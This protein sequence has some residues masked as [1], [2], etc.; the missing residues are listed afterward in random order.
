MRKSRLLGVAIAAGTMLA[1]AT[2][3][4]VGAVAVHVATSASAADS[5]A[6]RSA[7]TVLRKSGR[8][9]GRSVR[10]TVLDRGQTATLRT[11]LRAGTA[12]RTHGTVDLCARAGLA[13][14]LS[15]LTAAKT[16]T[17]P[18]ASSYGQL[19]YG[20]QDLQ[21]AYGLAGAKNASSTVAVVETGT[22]PKLASDLAVYRRAN[23]LPA[24]TVAGR[25]L[26]VVNQNGGTKLEPLPTGLD[27]RYGEEDVAGETA[28]D[29]DMV[30]AACPTCHI[31]VVDLP[32]KDAYFPATTARADEQFRDFGAGV[33]SAVRL[34]ARGVSLS[35]G[36]PASHYGDTVAAAP[37]NRP[38]VVI[39]ASSGD[40]GA[41][42]DAASWP[43]NLTTVISAGGTSLHVSGSGFRQSAWAGAG[44]SCSRDLRPAAGQPASV[45][46][47]CGGH[48]ASSDLSTVADPNTGVS[49]Y[50]SFA[51][52]SGTPL[53][54][55][56]FGGTSA[57]APF[58]A[59]M[60]VRA[61]VRADTLGPNHIYRAPTGSIVD[62]TAGTNAAGRCPEHD[63]RACTAGRGW[64]GPT[65]LG[66]PKGLTAFG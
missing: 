34:G 59:A 61:G 6:A 38:G 40:S 27:P 63:P 65:G 22:Y 64:D 30:S 19:G 51:P 8:S 54:F 5:G 48:R 49:V 9:S 11:Q 16:S 15:A 62:V 66:T 33:T 28:L 17:S 45:A 46:S 2:A 43:Q 26:R 57:S 37:F 44:S 4:P 52:A 39:T 47:A 3:S 58:L 18:L 56:A 35:Y 60:N 50:D 1:G 42:G 32:L 14:R 12:A 31:L 23:H 41:N 10:A 55:T 53:G 36:L 21:K 25:C 29:V 20:A 24:C 13:C 7:D